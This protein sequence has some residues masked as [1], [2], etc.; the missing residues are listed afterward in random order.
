MPIP[1]QVVSPKNLEILAE[2]E[3]S[4]EKP[5]KKCRIDVPQILTLS[6]RLLVQRI[7]LSYNLLSG[8]I[9]NSFGRLHMLS[10]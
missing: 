7:D 4:K 6:L 5:K 3:V 10:K 8:S 9:P 2:A 1:L